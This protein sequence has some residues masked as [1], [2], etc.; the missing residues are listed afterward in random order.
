M[1]GVKNKA[2][3][4]GLVAAL[5][6]MALSAP[7]YAAGGMLEGFA[8]VKANGYVEAQYNYNLNAPQNQSN[9]DR[10]FDNQAN[11]FTG[12]MAELALNKTSD[13]GVGFGLVLNYAQDARVLDSTTTSPVFVQQAYVSDR[14]FG[15]TVDLKFGKFATLAGAEVI[16]GPVNYNISR[17]LLFWYA[18][19]FTH[20]GIRGNIG[21]GM[22]TVSLVLGVNNGWDND[23][24]GDTGKTL[25][26][27]VGLTPTDKVTVLLNGYYGA[28]TNTTFG[29]DDARGLIDLVATLKATEGMTFVFNYD[30]GSQMAATGPFT[31]SALWQGYALYGN[32]A[33]GEKHAVSARYEYFDDNDG[34][35]TPF[36]A[37]V[38]GRELTLTYACKMKENLEWRAE[39]RHDE[40]NQD[41]FQEDDGT[42]TDSQNTI[43]VAAY[44]SF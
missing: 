26:A 16:E 44:Y 17:S 22:K 29:N 7:A 10:P 27:Q 28:E 1:Y 36:G 2:V 23:V 8:G 21:T 25:E 35:R 12:N 38:T 24:D 41:V 32:F 20:T 6:T 42:L 40:A 39:L 43:A 19:P 33:V 4:Q 3:K 14:V 15:D 5:A 13:K 18:I 30:R 11:S 37:P 9:V 31:G 34:V